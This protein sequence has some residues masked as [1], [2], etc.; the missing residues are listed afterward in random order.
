V[1]QEVICAKEV[2]VHCG[3]QS[4]KYENFTRFPE[5][6]LDTIRRVGSSEPGISYE[7]FELAQTLTTRGPGRIGKRST[8]TTERP[9]LLHN[10]SMCRKSSCTDPR[11]R[12]YALIG[13]SR[14]FKHPHSGLYV[15]YSR[16]VM[17][18]YRG[19]AQAI[20]EETNNLDVLCYA[21]APG[22]D[23]ATGQYCVRQYCLP[24]WTL[25]WSTHLS[26]LPLAFCPWVPKN[27]SANL[28]AEVVF[29]SDGNQI[30]ATG[31]C[32]TKVDYTTAPVPWSTSPDKVVKFLL[33]WRMYAQV[34]RDLDR[35]H[36][37]VE[38]GDAHSESFHRLITWDMAG[39]FSNQAE[40]WSRWA[41]EML[42]TMPLGKFTF[43][44]LQIHYLL[45]ISTKCNGRRM[46]CLDRKPA[47][48]TAQAAQKISLGLCPEETKKG[49]LLVVL[50]GCAVPVILRPQDGHYFLIGDAYVPEY[51]DDKAVEQEKEGFLISQK[52]EIH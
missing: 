3:S 40:W 34:G 22:I 38:Y 24:S 12:V 50:W 44:A 29:S 33:I 46:F 48:G 9:P 37:L 4:A 45:H 30:T 25:D 2:I 8:L 17:E 21:Q 28:R 20:I 15:D 36:L 43:S 10:L 49:D 31:T 32:I 14:P 42:N 13:I 18:V 23:P 6:I 19:A 7:I 39:D 51:M 47:S 1:I 26:I 41:Q 35:W 5:L 52:F 27:A 11:D 16:L